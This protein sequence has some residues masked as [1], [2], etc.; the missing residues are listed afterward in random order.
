MDIFKIA[1]L[2]VTAAIMCKFFNEQNEFGIYIKI[3]AAAMIMSVTAIMLSPVIESAEN[4]F[5]RT[6]SDKEYL[7]I[8]FKSLGICYVSQLAS[9]ICRDSGENA[10]AT[11]AELAGKAAL[12]ITALPLVD[13]LTKI[14]SSIA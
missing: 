5:E 3:V 9:D 12:V 7:T 8:L 11:Q 6:G 13:S 14:I 2:C 10:L 4:I 1:A